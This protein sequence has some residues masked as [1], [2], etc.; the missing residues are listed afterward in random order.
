MDLMKLYSLLY[1]ETLAGGIRANS[2]SEH[3]SKQYLQ[4]I[5]KAPT[6]LSGFNV[7]G[8]PTQM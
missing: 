2:S 1:D 7:F 5:P 3:C 8:A 6:A 4:N